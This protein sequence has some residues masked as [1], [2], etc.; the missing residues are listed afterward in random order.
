MQ[1][2]LK[3]EDLVNIHNCLNEYSDY[4]DSVEREELK[5]KN[6][7]IHIRLSLINISWLS[8]NDESSVKIRFSENQIRLLCIL[9]DKQIDRL[10]EDFSET[11]NR[12]EQDEIANDLISLHDTSRRIHLLLG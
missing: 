9:M 4:A 1:N 7:S 11:L 5:L 12:R 10:K 3:G 8:K 6:L 2:V